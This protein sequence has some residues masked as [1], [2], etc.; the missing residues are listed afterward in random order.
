MSLLSSPPWVT[1]L[2]RALRFL[3]RGTSENSSITISSENQ[4]SLTRTRT[5]LAQAPSWFSEALVALYPLSPR[6][7]MLITPTHCRSVSHL[8]SLVLIVAPVRVLLWLLSGSKSIPLDTCWTISWS[9]NAYIYTHLH[10]LDTSYLVMGLFYPTPTHLGIP[11]HVLTFALCSCRDGLR[12][13][14]CS[15]TM[16]C[17]KD[18]YFANLRIKK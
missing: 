6:H 9:K 10:W 2:S 11:R 8:L 12:H 5:S 7:P 4:D 1:A 18:V 14:P 15:H 16:I 3:Q 13:A 17:H